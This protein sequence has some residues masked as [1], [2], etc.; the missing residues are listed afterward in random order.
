MTKR[1]KYIPVYLKRDR[2]DIQGNEID[3]VWQKTLIEQFKYDDTV[4]CALQ[5]HSFSHLIS[6]TDLFRQNVIINCLLLHPK[7]CT[8]FWNTNH[9]LINYQ[10]NLCWLETPFETHLCIHDK[11]NFLNLNSEFKLNVFL[12]RLCNW[13][14]GYPSL[15][16]TATQLHKWGF[17]FFHECRLG[18]PPQSDM[19]LKPRNNKE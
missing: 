6:F 7:Q 4:C 15:S 11:V 9:C 1:A 3:E 5:V 2:I 18:F 14:R 13:N 8:H 16:P 10:L 12:L 19:Q 17:K